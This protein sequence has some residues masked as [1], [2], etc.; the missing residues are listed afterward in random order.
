MGA[1]S[2]TDMGTGADPPEA[3]NEAHTRAARGPQFHVTRHADR[4]RAE[5][6]R[7]EQ[8]GQEGP[9]PGKGTSQLMFL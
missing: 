6:R 5:E 3:R 1:E 8:K 9:G 7:A 4:R 2:K